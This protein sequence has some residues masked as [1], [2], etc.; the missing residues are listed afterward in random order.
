MDAPPG[1]AAILRDARIEIGC[2]RFRHSLGAE[3]GQA[4]LR[5]ALL[6]M[7]SELFLTVMVK[8]PHT[9][10]PARLQSSARCQCVAERLAHMG[11]VQAGVVALPRAAGRDLE[12]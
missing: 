1:R 2:C 8:P 4:R 11:A 6:R 9:L 10:L 12:I 5:C 7:R 3:V